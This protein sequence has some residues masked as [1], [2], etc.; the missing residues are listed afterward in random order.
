MLSMVCIQL[1]LISFLLTLSDIAVI[2]K[3]WIQEG[4]MPQYEPCMPSYLQVIDSLI[5]IS[6]PVL[7]DRSSKSRLTLDHCGP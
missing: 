1:V 2:P 4:K 3:A 7:Y 6:K 5:L